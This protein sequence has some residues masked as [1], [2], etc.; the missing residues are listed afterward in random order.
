MAK[1]YT[2]EASFSLQLPNSSS[3][4]DVDLDNLVEHSQA[5]MNSFYAGVKNTSRTT[6]DGGRPIEVVIT[7]PTKLVTQESGDSTLKTGDGKVSDFKYKDAKKQQ[8]IPKVSKGGYKA[9]GTEDPIEMEKKNVS[10]KQMND[11]KPEVQGEMSK[12]L[13]KKKEQKKSKGQKGKGK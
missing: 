3:W 10:N 2:T 12:N 5:K 11:D 4:Y 9:D 13:K 7:S 6:V 1:F 8:K